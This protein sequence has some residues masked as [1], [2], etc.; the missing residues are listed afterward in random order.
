MREQHCICSNRTLYKKKKRVS[1]VFLIVMKQNAKM[2]RNI[3]LLGNETTIVE[4]WLFF[5]FSSFLGNKTLNFKHGKNPIW[6]YKITLLKMCFQSVSKLLHYQN[7]KTLAKTPF[8]NKEN[9]VF[10]ENVYFEC[11]SLNQYQD[12][13]MHANHY[14]C[15]NKTPLQETRFFLLFLRVL[16]SKRLKCIERALFW[17]AEEHYQRKGVNEIQRYVPKR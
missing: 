15:G 14:I 4:T 8:M 13:K 2:H 10:T 9:N 6:E 7:V 3:F 11:F 17:N 5:C 1:G 16:S 12:A